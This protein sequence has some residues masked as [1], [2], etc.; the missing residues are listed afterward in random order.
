MGYEKRVFFGLGGGKTIII[1]GQEKTVPHR[2]ARIYKIATD[3]T[4]SSVAKYIKIQT[5]AEEAILSPK[6]LQKPETNQFYQAILDF[7]KKKVPVEKDSLRF[8]KGETQ[9]EKHQVQEKDQPKLG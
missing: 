6:K 8:F 4:L 1:D 5:V 9:V 7:D 3:P 2:V